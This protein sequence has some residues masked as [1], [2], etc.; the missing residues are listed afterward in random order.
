MFI[1]RA[2][3]K[4]LIK[5][6]YKTQ[7]VYVE[8]DGAGY[9]IKGQ[10]WDMWV[11]RD[12]FPKEYKADIIGVIDD[13]PEVGEGGLYTPE[14]IQQEIPGHESSKI[15][16]EREGVVFNDTGITFISPRR[17]VLRVLQSP[18][19]NGVIF[20]Y[21]H[22]IEGITNEIV[23]AEDGETQVEYMRN[24]EDNMITMANNVMSFMTFGR[25]DPCLLKFKNL[26]EGQWV[27]GLIMP[28]EDDDQEEEEA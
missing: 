10:Y 13:L 25:W 20:V 1:R 27:R 8:N 18:T 19:T 16:A 15:M 11:R 14:G 2:K 9:R 28:E 4:S 22:V 23:D 3:L 6:A 24:P 5:M 26:L 17:E 7:G 21:N 12:K